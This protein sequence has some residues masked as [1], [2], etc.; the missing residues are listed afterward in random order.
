MNKNTLAFPYSNSRL[1][2][3]SFAAK[4]PVKKKSSVKTQRVVEER[5]PRDRHDPRSGPED[6]SSLN[7]GKLLAG[8]V[9]PCQCQKNSE[10]GEGSLKHFASHSCTTKKKINIRS[11]QFS[12]PSTPIPP[13]LLFL[14]F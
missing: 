7:P 12:S 13:F 3:A 5:E 11:F 2:L 1:E 9:V 14:F 8:E 6:P 10:G 4:T